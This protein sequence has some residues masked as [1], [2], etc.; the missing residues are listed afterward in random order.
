MACKTE[1]RDVNGV[2]YEVTQFPAQTGVKLGFTLMTKLA[3]VLDLAG[4]G[5]VLEKLPKAIMQ[6][7]ANL[8]EGEFYDLLKR[9][10]VNDCVKREG[11]RV[12]F[13]VDYSGELPEAMKA[14]A[15]VMEVNYRDF[16]TGDH[17]LA[18]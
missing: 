16:F 2:S 1:T 7:G 17:G 18:V 4:G 6:L 14:A 13:E 5:A 12:D 3:P 15:F 8:K 11:R 9:L 10:L